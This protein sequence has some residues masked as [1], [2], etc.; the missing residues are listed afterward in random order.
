MAMKRFVVLA[1][2]ATGLSVAAPPVQA[3]RF[4]GSCQVAGEGGYT[5]PAGY[6]PAANGWWMHG[7]GGCTGTLDGVAVVNHPVRLRL[8]FED[9]V[10]SCAGSLAAG[11]GLLE[12][13]SGKRWTRRLRFRQDHVGPFAA[14]TGERAGAGLAYLTAYTQLARQDPMAP[15]QCATGTL[16]WFAAEWA[17]KTL[18]PLEG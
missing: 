4:D 13:R 18:Q 2:V 5:S 14:I 11:E 1:S 12:F 16:T 17:M 9:P 8:S 10:G 3:A 6:L 15:V 7:D